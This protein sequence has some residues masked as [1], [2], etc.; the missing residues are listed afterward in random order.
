MD[1]FA[2]PVIGPR[3]AR[4]RW[5]AMTVVRIR[6]T[7]SSSSLRKQGPITTGGCVMRKPS[8]SASLNKRHGV[9]MSASAHAGSL[10][11]QGRQEIHAGCFTAARNLGAFLPNAAID[12]PVSAASTSAT[13]W[14]RRSSLACLL[15]RSRPK[16]TLS[17]ALFDR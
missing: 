10:L 13:I 6:T 1:S 4:T 8:N 15:N 9:A 5:L 2:E 3:Y 7:L 12:F 16:I 14:S 11:S 17:V